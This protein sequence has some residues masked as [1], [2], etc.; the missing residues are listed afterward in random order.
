MYDWLL[1]GYFHSSELKVIKTKA[2]LRLV[3]LSLFRSN[4]NSL[5]Y[6][7]ILAY[8]G[9]SFYIPTLSCGISVHWLTKLVLKPS[10]IKESCTLYRKYSWKLYT[11]K[12]F[13]SAL[14]QT[15]PGLK[16]CI[17]WPAYIS[18]DANNAYAQM[19]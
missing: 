10:G 9:I 8:F 6:R 16:P 12:S 5:M 7:Y 13:T 14:P 17:N 4:L 15:K 18:P 3:F 1:I 11:M 2:L 19:A